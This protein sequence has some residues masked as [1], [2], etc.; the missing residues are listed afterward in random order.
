MTG[1]RLIAA[2]LVLLCLSGCAEKPVPVTTVPTTEQTVPPTTQAPETT[3]PTTGPTTEPEPV[4]VSPL[5]VEDFLL[6]VEEY[7][8]QR[9]YPPEYV[10][11]H[12]ISAVMTHREEPYHLPHVRDI[13]VQYN[14]SVH[15]II[16]R[17]GTVHCYVPEDRVAWHAGAGDWQEEERFHNAM[18]QYAIGIELV[19]MGSEADMSIYMSGKEYRAL[20]DSL[21]GFT[22]AQYDSLK[23]LVADICERN[24]IPMDRDHVIGHEEYS[25]TK[26][27]PGDLFDW[28]R[29]IP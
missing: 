1:G 13:F 10:M 27:D 21:K 7:S 14:T 11:V 25:P 5:A 29:L 9:Q 16:E 4:F 24:A 15:Y 17:D 26:T 3:E 20:D 2:G 22:Q 6:P 8:W 23:L 12:F 28:S 18:N 19:A